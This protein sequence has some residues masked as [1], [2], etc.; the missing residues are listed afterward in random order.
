MLAGFLATALAGAAPA[1][2]VP[3]PVVQEATGH[4]W[5]PP[6]GPWRW[7][8][9]PA[10]PSPMVDVLGTRGVAWSE[11]G[12]GASV[13]VR[14]AD[15]VPRQG[16]RLHISNHGVEVHVRDPSGLRYALDTLD[17]LRAEGA[18]P[19]G[20]LADAPVLTERWVHV[21]LPGRTTGGDPMFPRQ[22]QTV[23]DVKRMAGPTDYLPLLRQL[24]DDAVEARLTGLLVELN[25]MWVF[26]SHPELALPEAIPLSALSPLVADLR[27]RGVTVYPLLPLF[28]HQEQLLAPV[29]PEL[30]LVPMRAF[31]KKRGRPPDDLFWWNPLYNPRL[32]R[33]RQL[34]ADLLADTMAIFDAPV[35]HVGHDEAGALRFVDDSD[36]TALF[37]ESIAY[38]HELAQRHG[39]TLAVWADMLLDGTR[40]AGTAHGNEAGIKTWKVART[41]PKDI[42]FVDWQYHG[43]PRAWPEIG[44]LDDVPSLR[45]LAATGHP[46]MG[47]AL[48]R[49]VGTTD[50]NGP[51]RR[52]I[53]QSARIARVLAELQA[54]G[55]GRVHGHLTTQYDWTPGRLRPLPGTTIA[56]AVYMAGLHGWTGG[57]TVWPTDGTSGDTPPLRD[58]S[59][60]RP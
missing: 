24:G 23:G 54:S 14:A 31:P 42:L 11:A 39:A 59:E 30:L 58:R 8:A 3:L 52:H 2:V 44:P 7:S 35:V 37:R 17:Q 46:V 32:P 5:T 57:Q 53:E 21:A 29:Y 20:H 56:G 10:L 4:T 9:A 18:L 45:Y 40:T 12:R 6:E 1:A 38:A 16:Y 51:H 26:P 36:P 60:H 48:G 47:A 34:V 25:G 15:D 13:E 33:T 50:P 41:L 19:T 55:A 43:A 22:R 27:S 49:P 28:S